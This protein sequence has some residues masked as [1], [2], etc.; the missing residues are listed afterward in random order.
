MPEARNSMKM[1]FVGLAIVVAAVG[2]GIG[3]AAMKTMTTPDWYSANRNESATVLAD[4]SLASPV[5]IL[6]GDVVISA[7]ELNQMVTEAIAQQPYTAPLLDVAKGVNT[8]IKDGRIES[9]MVMNLAD[10]PLEALPVEGQQ[11]VE[12]LT[13]T[14]PFLANRDVYLGVEG[15]PKIVNGA[16]SLEDTHVKL[17]QL[18]L[19]VAN[20]ASQLGLSQ[21]D[22]EAQ[23]EAALSQQGLTPDDIQIVDGQLVITG[24]PQ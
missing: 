6:P 17:G 9:G 22:I 12:K 20:I 2:G 23:I 3:Y 8:S 4:S 19:P 10:V 14:F 11:A 24:L 1:V 15:S 16:L 7:D 21:T 5:A 18:R 13:R